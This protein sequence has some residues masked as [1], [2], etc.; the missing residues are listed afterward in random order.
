[1]PWH[2]TPGCVQ[3]RPAVPDRR[4]GIPPHCTRQVAGVLDGCVVLPGLAAGQR[5]VKV[6]AALPEDNREVPARGLEQVV[7]EG[8]VQPREQRPVQAGTLVAA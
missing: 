1:M 2:V 3:I 5:E 6:M 8:P 4:A 7:A